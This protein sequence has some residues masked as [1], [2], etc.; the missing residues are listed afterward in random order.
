MQ[1]IYQVTVWSN[2]RL[3]NFSQMVPRMEKS[4]SYNLLPRA[5]QLKA[6]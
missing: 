2:N 6:K 3:V 4:L 1:V 5:G